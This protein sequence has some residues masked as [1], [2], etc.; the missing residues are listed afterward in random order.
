AGSRPG[1]G[2]EGDGR[3]RRP[4]RQDPDV[5]LSPKSGYGPPDQSFGPQP[6]GDHGGSA[7]RAGEGPPAGEPRGSQRGLTMAAERRLTVRG[8]LDA[9][10]RTL[11]AAGLAEPRREAVRLLADL[12]E[13]SPAELTLAGDRVLEPDR[14]RWIDR[15]VARRADGEPLPYVTGVAGFRNLVLRSDRRALIPRPET[16]G[17]VEDR[18][19]T[20][21]NS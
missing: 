9:A 10:T 11:A 12:L 18:K 21:L 16:E 19:S 13:S 17:L 14:R 1:P 20:R 4:L 5:Q 6:R 2:S 15:A 8:A 3:H 7:R